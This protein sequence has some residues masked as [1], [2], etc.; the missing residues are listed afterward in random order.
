MTTPPHAC[1]PFDVQQ[2][3]LFALNNAA[4]EKARENTDISSSTQ[5]EGTD[6]KIKRLNPTELAARGGKKQKRAHPL[7]FLFGEK[8]CRNFA[9]L[10]DLEAFLAEE[11]LSL[12]LQ[13]D[14]LDTEYI[15]L[16]KE[17]ALPYLSHFTLE[18]RIDLFKMLGDSKKKL[19]PLK[20]EDIRNLCLLLSP[21]G[22]WGEYKSFQSILPLFMDYD[23]KQWRQFTEF[24]TPLLE[25][26]CDCYWLF[27]FFESLEEIHPPQWS[28]FV[29]YFIRYGK[30]CAQDPGW[31]P[32]FNTFHS[33]EREKLLKGTTMEMRK[34]FFE[35]EL[36][37]FEQTGLEILS[38]LSD[39]H[40]K[41]YYTMMQTIGPKYLPF[42]LYLPKLL[43]LYKEDFTQRSFDQ[44]AF[45]L[46]S[47]LI[48][49][50]NLAFTLFEGADLEIFHLEDLKSCL[51]IQNLSESWPEYYGLVEFYQKAFS[52]E[53]NPVVKRILA[54]DLVRLLTS[55]DEQDF[56]DTAQEKMALTE[57]LK[58]LNDYL[59]RV[60]FVRK[61][62]PQTHPAFAICQGTKGFIDLSGNTFFFKGGLSATD[63][64]CYLK[65]LAHSQIQYTQNFEVV[66]LKSAP[67]M[68]E[69]RLEFKIPS[70]VD[71]GG[72]SRSLFSLI[73]SEIVKN[74]EGCGIELDSEG[75][76]L[77]K[78]DASKEKTELYRDFGKF[79][80]MAKKLEIPLGKV[81]H[82]KTYFMMR[83]LKMSIEHTSL[84]FYQELD[85]ILEGKRLINKKRPKETDLE[86]LKD[87]YL[88]DS[89]E[90]VP[91]VVHQELKNIY[92]NRL[93]AV[94]TLMEGMDFETLFNIRQESPYVIAYQI[95]GK[96]LTSENFSSFI[97]LEIE[98][99]DDPFALNDL[100]SKKIK[101][102][103]Q[104][105][106]LS[107][108]GDKCAHFA[109]ATTGSSAISLNEKLK[110]SIRPKAKND[111]HPE[112][113]C[114]LHTCSSSVDIF[115]DSLEEITSILEG[116]CLEKGF[117]AV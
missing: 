43:R 42:L 46:Q 22:G 61:N 21:F 34:I 56:L 58:E 90:E 60:R 98:G 116:I 77:L 112:T 68:I 94:R 53:T 45:Y 89:I 64:P 65:L 84:A 20:A 6:A 32:F 100:D 97:D 110:L 12:D 10:G 85:R 107:S 104:D 1:K 99:F 17:A 36:V 78:D 37:P 44:F 76:P 63:Y 7:D 117:N 5:K 103:V 59:E 51:C 48:C 50:E 66:F 47:G 4:Q 14:S 31:I 11:G 41:S 105:W 101:E 79:L 70:T 62:I 69:G 29:T 67:E 73:A 16:F 26:G 80:A 86:K 18:N 24:L 114:F 106:F 108:S 38:N 35:E 8:I 2:L 93:R 75:F 57:L 102:H 9:V 83:I 111:I 49:F 39:S 81:F 27:K 30:E 109:H 55:L 74:S 33:Q 52:L 19:P 115:A 96:P 25:S 92:Q 82:L 87:L 88:L 13:E 54:E 91:S 95:E 72:P 28:E 40:L 23:P 15:Q 113:S 71:H 3:N